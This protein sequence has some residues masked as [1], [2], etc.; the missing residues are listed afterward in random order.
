M[1]RLRRPKLRQPKLR[2]LMQPQQRQKRQQP[3][4]RLKRQQP[5]Q[6][7]VGADAPIVNHVAMRSVGRK[8]P[9]ATADEIAPCFQAEAIGRVFLGP[10]HPPE[11][12]VWQ[13]EVDQFGYIFC[14]DY[15]CGVQVRPQVKAEPLLAHYTQLSYGRVPPT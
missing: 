2:N 7:L 6:R 10:P 4:Q 14:A 12:R 8:R 15:L 1:P 11:Q 9:N 3:Q 13:P 5:Q